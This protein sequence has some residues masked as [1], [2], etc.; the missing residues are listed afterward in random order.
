MWGLVSPYGYGSIGV[1]PFPCVLLTSASL[2]E[3]T[4][5]DTYQID[6][7]LDLI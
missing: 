5:G 3:T 1:S 2:R 7:C 6:T 4:S